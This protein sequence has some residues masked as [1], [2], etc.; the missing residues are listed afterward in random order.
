MFTELCGHLSIINFLHHSKNDDKL[1]LLQTV[2]N[3]MIVQAEQVSYAG[4]ETVHCLQIINI[5]DFS[6][7]L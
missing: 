4:M 7:A 6:T 5:A 3:R 1:S 2:I